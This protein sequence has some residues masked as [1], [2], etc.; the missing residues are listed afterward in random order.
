MAFKARTTRPEK[1]NKYYITKAN[2]GYSYAIKGNPSDKYCDV[3]SNCV[4]Y[5]YGRFNE[6][7]GY[8]SCKYLSPTNA[9][10]F[11]QY[12]GSCKTGMTPKLGACMVWQKGNTLSGSDGA[13]HVAIVEKIISQTEI[14]TSESGWGSS[15]PFWTQTRKKGNGNWGQNSSYKFL[16]FIYNPAVSDSDTTNQKEEIKM[17]YTNSSLVNCTVKSP[18][19]SGTRTHK[20]DRIT[21]H[22]VVGQLS[23]EG[24]GGCFT[25]T[26]RQ[27]SCNYGIGYDGRVCLVVDEMNRSWCSSSSANDQRAITI[28]CASDA[29]APYAFKTAVYNKLVKLCID[30]CKRN[31]LKKVIWIAD[32]NKSLAYAPKSGECV[33]T[34][35]RWFANK[36]CPGDWMYSRMGQLASDINKGLWTT[37]NPPTSSTQKPATNTTYK[38]GDIVNFKGGKHYPSASATNGTTCK[39]G[40]AKVT[41]VYPSGKHIYHLVAEKNGGSNVYGWVD[42]ST[43]STI[44][45]NT[46]TTPT[47]SG[48]IVNGTKL[49][50]KNVNLYASASATQRA[51]VKNGTYYVW[52]K[53]VVNN[54]VRITNSTANVG[55][56]GQ[57][58][59]W[60]SY[61]D[62]KN[63]ISGTSTTS[64]TN[65]FKAYKVKITAD[66]L[67]VRKGA[68]TNY[69]TN[70]SVKKNEIYT[71]I[72]ESTGK[73]ATKW[74]KLKSGA[75]YIASDFTAKI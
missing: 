1:G 34:V 8:G 73:G 28:E 55:K 15:T 57:V 46:T 24:I 75:G 39:A 74:L 56:S 54:R 40:T 71:I 45:T 18:N 30:I 72:G 17:G 37:T 48:E 68:G 65:T 70:G 49:T 51:G 32:K 19:H 33:L 50:L 9:E 6:I 27:A 62:A 44:N 25:S 60:I 22:C 12:K 36:S 43:V 38:K 31:G 64:T 7:G 26:S 67:N 13:G 63:S 2:G 52:N 42:A 66:V 21:P 20:I 16:G 69:S 10:N 3:L 14:V 53:D 23:A 5:A 29:T 4:G 61:T 47:Q 41:S 59:G 58:T 35:H 11:M